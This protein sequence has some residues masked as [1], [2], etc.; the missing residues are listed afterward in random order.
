M[1]PP[2][3]FPQITGL[4]QMTFITELTACVKGRVDIINV[5]ISA[6]KDI[7]NILDGKAVRGDLKSYMTDILSMQ[8]K[9]SWKT[10][11]TLKIVISTPNIIVVDTKTLQAILMRVITTTVHV[12][13]SVLPEESTLLIKNFS[14]TQQKNDNNDNMTYSVFISLQS[15]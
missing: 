8:N 14:V 5:P 11:C 4:E 13:Q 10:S 9:T 3:I 15:F 12:S 6:F 1:D 2:E 7:E